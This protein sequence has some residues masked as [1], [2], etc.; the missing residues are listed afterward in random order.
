MVLRLST[1]VLWR[2]SLH[3]VD[4]HRQPFPCQG[5]IGCRS[6]AKLLGN[7]GTNAFRPCLFSADAGQTATVGRELI[8]PTIL[9]TT[10]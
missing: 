7:L 4:I 2:K 5:P 3:L 1:I 6:S 8:I 9:A 10:L